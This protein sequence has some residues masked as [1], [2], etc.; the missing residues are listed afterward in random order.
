MARRTLAGR[1]ELIEQIG[2]STWRAAD[3]ELGRDVLVRL[4]AGEVATTL[5][6]PNIVRV[7]DQGEEDGEPYAVL[8]YLPGGSLE[9]RLV[10]GPLTDVE[11]NSVAA[12]V[13]TAL[14]Y[15]HAQ[16]ITHG[17][18]G[19]ASVLFDAEGRA[20][21]TGFTGAGTTA[22]DTRALAALLELVGADAIA[23][24]AA[25]V[26][27]VMRAQAPP[28]ATSRRRLALAAVGVLVLLAAGVAAALIATSGGSSPKAATSSLSVPVPTVSPAPT[29]QE[30]PPA[31]TATTTAETTQ[32][33]TAPTTRPATT[34]A[35]PPTTSTPPPATTAP[36]PTTEPPPPTTEP[37]PTTTEV[38][39]P[40]T[41]G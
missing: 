34:T 24:P 17:S 29:T 33:T 23:V 9:Q 26:T 28:A 37:P 27:E 7:F 25:E 16:G 38:P 5:A 41:T 15:A 22:D 20:K 4:R 40:T 18:L 12:D 35:P 6:H 1:Y 8:E 14:A 19:P 36:P 2:D 21:L 30:E 13:G 31:S 39:P 11:A 3:T 32:A 10:A